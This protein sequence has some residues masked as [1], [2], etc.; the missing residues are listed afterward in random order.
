MP[1]GVVSRSDRCLLAPMLDRSPRRAAIKDRVLHGAIPVARACVRY[2]RPSPARE[3]L[4]QSRI[5]PYLAWHSHRFVARTVFGCRLRGDT[6]EVLQQH[7]YYFGVWEP[8]LTSWLRARLRPGDVFVDVG[9]NIGYFTLLGFRI[10]GAR[11]SVVAIE[12]SPSI[13]DALSA[14]IARNRAANVR[15]VNRVAAKQ[16]GMRTVYVGP[17]SHSGLTTVNQDRGWPAESETQAATL[18]EIVGEPEWSNARIIKIDVEGA[19]DEV[20]RGMVGALQRTRAELEVVVEIH[21]P[22]GAAL[23]ALFRDAGFNAYAMEIDYSPL[24]YRRDGPAPVARRIEQLP[25]REVD[26]IFSRHAAE[27]I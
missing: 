13:F 3:R 2:R 14:N 26:V 18:P 12:A 7:V 20:A 4:W 9:A 19:E 8:N 25:D 23:F 6:Q 27:V 16:P 21:P 11:G 22:K 17:A 10:V 24:S 15:A 1:E 5:E